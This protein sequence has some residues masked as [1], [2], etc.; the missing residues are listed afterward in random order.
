MERDFY[1]ILIN[2]FY[3]NYIYTTLLI[4]ILNVYRNFI[5]EK[6]FI[7]F[8]FTVYKKNPNY[9][10]LTTLLTELSW[11]YTDIWHKI[12]VIQWN[13]NVDWWQERRV[14]KHKKFSILSREMT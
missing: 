11:F 4:Y 2:F 14:E 5:I 8:S 10:K 12:S 3:Q 13:F 9:E 1:R 6:L 7:L